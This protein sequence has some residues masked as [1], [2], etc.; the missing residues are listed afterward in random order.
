MKSK[1]I[2]ISMISALVG[3]LITYFGKKK[4][5]EAD[6]TNNKASD[7][8][9]INRCCS[10]GEIK[11]NTEDQEREDTITIDGFAK[12]ICVDSLNHY[13]SFIDRGMYPTETKLSRLNDIRAFLVDGKSDF[14]CIKNVKINTIYSEHRIFSNKMNSSVDP[15]IKLTLIS[16]PPS[17]NLY[18][19]PLVISDEDGNEQSVNFIVHSSSL[20]D[21]IANIND[22]K[23]RFSFVFCKCQEKDVPSEFRHNPCLVV[24]AITRT[25]ENVKEDATEEEDQNKKNE[26]FANDV[27][28]RTRAY[29]SW[30]RYNSTSTVKLR[31]FNTIQC[32]ANPAYQNRF[33]T[34]ENIKIA[35]LNYEKQFCVYEKDKNTP[36]KK[37]YIQNVTMVDE[38]GNS[39]Y[40]NIITDAN[41]IRSHIVT[42]ASCKNKFFS[43]NFCRC[44]S[45]VVPDV[46]YNIIIFDILTA[47]DARIK[48]QWEE[49]I[50]VLQNVIATI[51]TK[52]ISKNVLRNYKYDITEKISDIKELI[53]SL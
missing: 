13:L 30:M 3:G 28:R 51:N 40:V 2:V 10:Y 42:F 45:E 53:E 14:Y 41:V 46:G 5:D 18:I 16:L 44:P 1:T 50:N 31:D 11:E 4:M 27:S 48:A 23:T 12:N 35:S 36:K 37:V 26:A 25:V 49:D 22:A 33:Y 21:K 47:D 19:L 17:A 24:F 39:R 20:R 8:D 52:G 29:I 9:D 32:V 6:N 34:L 15:S 38:K 7:E 43:F